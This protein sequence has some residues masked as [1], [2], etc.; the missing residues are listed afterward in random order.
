MQPRQL[1]FISS[2]THTQMSTESCVQS[3]VNVIPT[4]TVG[5]GVRGS[6]GARKIAIKVP[7]Q[8]SMTEDA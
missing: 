8:H 1:K 3:E 2:E 6:E 5:D 7:A 4:E